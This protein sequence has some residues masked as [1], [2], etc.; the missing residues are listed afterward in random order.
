[1]TCAHCHQPIP[2]DAPCCHL[3]KA[4]TRRGAFHATIGPV[5][6]SLL[7]WALIVAIMA[8]MAALLL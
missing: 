4:P 3:C 6:G 1:M 7:A 5:I 2:A 8:A